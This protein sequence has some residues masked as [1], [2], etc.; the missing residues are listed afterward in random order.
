[1]SSC[2]NRQGWLE[3]KQRGSSVML[4][5]YIFFW[6]R[7]ETTDSHCVCCGFF[8]MRLDRSRFCFWIWAS[9][10]IL[11]W[12]NSCIQAT[13]KEGISNAEALWL[14]LE[15]PPDAGW[16]WPCLR[17]SLEMLPE[18]KHLWN[19]NLS[20]EWALLNLIFTNRALQLNLCATSQKDS[21]KDRLKLK[22]DMLPPPASMPELVRAFK[23]L[24]L[25]RT[26][27]FRQAYSSYLLP[28][29]LPPEVHIHIWLP[30]DCADDM[31]SVTES[32][33]NGWHRNCGWGWA[34]GN[35]DMDSV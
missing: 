20:E 11:C 31:N 23:M 25:W 32:S 33:S 34:L 22:G 10:E 24:P 7:K 4:V 35:W 3:R 16:L 26:N 19:G 18:A 28:W 5:R 12:D 1:M 9:L 13:E 15:Q 27:H 6:A 14:A 21:G 29:I 8:Q 17:L 2:C 30:K